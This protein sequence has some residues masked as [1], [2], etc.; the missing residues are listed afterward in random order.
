MDYDWQKLANDV[1]IIAHVFLGL[2]R[3]WRAW[4]GGVP[5]YEKSGCRV[6]AFHEMVW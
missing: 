1:P 4:T 6:G 5:L 3:I 2:E